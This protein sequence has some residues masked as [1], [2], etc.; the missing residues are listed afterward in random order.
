MTN[1]RRAGDLILQ[2]EH[3]EDINHLLLVG[4]EKNQINPFLSC[5]QILKQLKMFFRLIAGAASSCVT[6]GRQKLGGEL[7]GVLPQRLWKLYKSGAL[8]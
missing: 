3:S 7:S 2:H 6:S 8:Q 4:G 5:I 1:Q